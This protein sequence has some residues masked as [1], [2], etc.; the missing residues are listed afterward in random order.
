MAHVQVVTV[1]K[2]AL[3][4]DLHLTGTVTYNA[5]KTTPIFSAVGGPVHEILVA[6]GENVKAGQ[7]LLT[8]NSPDYSLDSLRLPQGA[9]RI[10]TCRQAVPAL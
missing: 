2:Q 4:R 5:F 8:V 6:P 3:V 10:S 9:R 1:S 7:T